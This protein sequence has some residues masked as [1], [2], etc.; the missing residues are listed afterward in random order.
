MLEKMDRFFNDRIVGYEEHQLNEISGA[1]EFYPFTASCLPVGG[2]KILDLGCG[3]G[4]ELNYYFEIS[5]AAE[6]VCIDLA[7]E[8]LKTLK[9]KFC[10][11]RVEI[12]CGSYFDVPFGKNIYDAVVSVKSLH[13]FTQ[14]E[15]FFFTGKY[16]IA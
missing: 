5:P 6:V 4:L 16:I 11:K 1:R 13:H 14:S 3:T 2:V 10:D 15:K 9:S 12:I 8:M 7:A